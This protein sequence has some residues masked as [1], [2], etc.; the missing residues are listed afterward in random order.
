ML[1][2]MSGSIQRSRIE[3]L[4]SREVDRQSPTGL[5]LLLF[6]CVVLV[7]LSVLAKW[8]VGKTPLRKP[9][10]GE[11]IVSTKPRPKS[12]YN[13][14]GLV[15]CFIVWIYLICQSYMIYFILLWHDAASLC[16][17]Q[18]RRNRGSGGSMNRGPRA[19]GDP[20]VVGPQKIFRQDFLENH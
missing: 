5:I 15:Y 20:G 18:W 3:N 13:F 16:W 12:V 2:G 1:D 19:P 7:K 10:S 9:N 17:K 8:L 14:F 11:G 4:H 6:S